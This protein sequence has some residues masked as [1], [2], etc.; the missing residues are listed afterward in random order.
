MPADLIMEKDKKT[1]LMEGKKEDDKHC[2]NNRR[3]QREATAFGSTPYIVKV[4]SWE[5]Y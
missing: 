4:D 2:F 5:W 1:D 3:M